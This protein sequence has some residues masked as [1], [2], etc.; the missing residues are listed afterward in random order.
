MSADLP[1]TSAQSG[2]WF[3]HHLR[4]GS[5]AYNTGEYLDIPGPVDEDLFE[6][7]VRSV[8]DETDSLRVRFTVGADGPRQ[9]VEP[10]LDPTWSMHRADLSSA[11][12]PHAAAVAWM[13]AEL[14]TP[15]DLLRGPLFRQALFRIAPDRFLW[16]QR[17]HHIV[18][19]GFS[20]SLL[21]RR[22]AKTYTALVGGT[23]RRGTAFGPLTTLLAHDAD[24]AGSGQRARDREFW[25][26]RLAGRDAPVSP[27]GRSAEA[28]SGFLRRTSS[29]SAP[30]M[31]ALRGAAQHAGTTWPTAVIATVAAYLHRVTGKGDVV[32]SM[33]V[34]GRTDPA[35]LAVPGMVANVVPL[36]LQVRPE[37]NLTALVRQVA[38]EVGASRPHQRYRGEDLRRDLGEDEPQQVTFGP[39]ANIMS[40]YY[41][42]EFAGLRATAHNL[43][44]GPVEDLSIS[45]YDR[46]DGTRPRVDLDANPALYSA[47]ELASHERRFLHFLQTV[48]ADPH[49][50]LGSHDVLSPEERHRTVV[51]W[52][53]TSRPFPSTTVPGAFAAQ[54]ARTPGASAVTFGDLTLSYEEL[55][56]RAN[57]LAHRLV[58]RGV[59]G[60]SRVAVLMER[61]LDV[62]VSVLAISKAGGAYVPLDTRSP[63]ARL[64]HVMAETG[65]TVLLTH[66]ATE[67]HELADG[68]TELVVDASAS[69]LPGAPADD[70]RVPLHP[71]HL[72]CVLYT[73][74]STGTPKGVALTH[75]N[76]LG[77][78]SDH[79][80]HGQN[81]PRVLAHSPHAF[82]AS[83][84]EWWVPLLN[85]GQVVMA[86]PGDLDLAAYRRLIVEQRVSALWLTAGLFGVLADE[87][88]DALSG[89]AQVW[90]GGDVVPADAVRR[91]LDRCPDTVVVAAYGPTEGT[92]FTTRTVL[93]PGRPV[94][95]VVPLGRPMD[96]RRV[97]VLDASLSPV[98]PGVAGELYVAGAGVARGY[99]NRPR[100]T[101]RHFVPCP[102][103][104]PG[105]RMYG[106]GDV[107][108]WSPDG[109]LEFLGRVDDQI[110]LR[111]FRIELAEIEA[112]LAGHPGVARATVLAALDP[113]GEK[114][115]IGYVVPAAGAPGLDVASL[116]DHASAVLPD[117][118]VPTEIIAVDAFPLTPRGKIDRSALPAPRFPSLS[119]GPVSGASG[120]V[121][122]SP[123]EQAMCAL[124]AE[125]LGLPEV[126]VHDSFFALGGNSLLATRLVNRVRVRSGRELTLG[127]L[128]QAR[129]PA[130]LAEA[131]E[132][133]PGA[134]LPGPV[135][136][137]TTQTETTGSVA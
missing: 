76:V 42:L 135:R 45:V 19:D 56:E 43:S 79:C 35:E 23:D 67:E 25:A 131:V 128:F 87:S 83:T 104:E 94:P 75:R 48:A 34:T 137:S 16:Y 86:P 122:A 52:N 11:P 51:E 107:V 84:Y 119:S 29:L 69:G 96:N 117:Y 105:E 95:D 55:N 103:G 134:A 77:M 53:D 101:A 92:T 109:D 20:M 54:V 4:A 127:A 18:V 63:A 7:A 98:P 120:P 46:S 64:R 1:L 9:T 88:P 113:S 72:A 99:L 82:D 61:S 33:P 91:V 66:R 74:G 58:A 8:V 6:R 39:V 116:R 44:N 10:S 130:R 114:R 38:D 22:V 65:A 73:S 57:Q 62:V 15:V 106:T 40:F 115:L 32:L 124:F 60:E 136:R 37:Q 111:G 47:A 5:A 31:A 97:Y 85:G 102:F 27:A 26:A 41:R 112:L 125:V 108:R 2:I 89:V 129:T 100:W 21:A 133:S 13:R 126:G 90:T 110:K 24:Y 36:R 28:S 78:T 59:R 132:D 68:V 3:A 123:A 71:D 93:R 12:D 14:A 80:W 30:T 121:T 81:P 49:R 118:M 50:P 70:P 17:V